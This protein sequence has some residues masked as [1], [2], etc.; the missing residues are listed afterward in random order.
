M[1]IECREED[2]GFSCQIEDIEFKVGSIHGKT[3]QSEGIVEV[4]TNEE[5]ECRI[6]GSQLICT[7]GIETINAD[8]IDDWRESDLV[9]T[10][11]TINVSEASTEDLRESDDYVEGPNG[12]FWSSSQLR[13]PGVGPSEWEELDES[14]LSE[15]FS[16]DDGE[17]AK[18]LAQGVESGDWEMD[19]AIR[20]MERIYGTHPERSR[21]L[22]NQ[23]K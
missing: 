2:D 3:N 23:F 6:H 17:T 8:S 9:S 10:P 14:S 16:S 1:D 19:D 11:N 5:T 21:K 15:E 20:K 4:E 13:I 7:E 22:F 18:F 12:K